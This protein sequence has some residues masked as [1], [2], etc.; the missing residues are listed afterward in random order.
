MQLLLFAGLCEKQQQEM[1]NLTLKTEPFKVL[2]F[3]ILVVVQHVKQSV[4][5]LL[6]KGGWVMLLSVV[7]MALGFVLMAIDGPHEKVFIFRLVLSRSLFGNML[8]SGKQTENMFF[9]TL[10]NWLSRSRAVHIITV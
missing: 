1:E 3:F 9:R 7:A 8:N 2:K 5:Y 6:A 4:A 10:S